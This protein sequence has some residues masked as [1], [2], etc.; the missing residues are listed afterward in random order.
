M[1][2]GR[3][4]KK[5]KKKQLFQPPEGWQTPKPLDTKLYPQ[6]Q[7]LTGRQFDRLEVLGHIG[8]HPN[9][10]HYWL[11]RCSCPDR[12]LVYV[13]GDYLKRKLIRSCDCLRIERVRAATTIHGKQKTPAWASWTS[14]VQR[15]RYPYEV[16]K[17]YRD[18]KICERWQQFANFYADMGD[19]PPGHTL[20]RID[21]TKGY[22][23]GSQ[24]CR[25]C[26][27]YK[28]AKNCRWATRKQQANNIKNNLR[29]TL[30]GQTRTVSE[31][32]DEVGISKSCLSARHR[33][34][35]PDEKV[36]TTP[37]K[38]RNWAGRLKK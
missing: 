33:M 24:E 15:C 18:I 38:H 7:D 25:E 4:R 27:R 28:R 26:K 2:A 10:L 22:Y 14:M 19:R 1:S 8:R 34:G 29:L 11:C 23:C 9:K 37:V 17:R 31:W 36:L 13:C 16:Y 3:K 12:T 35:W 5:P 21:G 32:A 6:V 20:D 30:N